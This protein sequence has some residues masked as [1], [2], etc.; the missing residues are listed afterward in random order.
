MVLSTKKSFNAVIG[1]PYTFV[2]FVRGLPKHADRIIITVLN[3][4]ACFEQLFGAK[5]DPF[6][7]KTFVNI[8]AL[9]P[10]QADK[11]IQHVLSRPVLFHRYFDN[12]T[13]L[14]YAF[15]KLPKQADLFME[16][17]RANPNE[18][19]KLFKTKADLEAAARL[20]PKYREFQANSVAE[21][22]K[23]LTD[24]N[25]EPRLL[26]AASNDNAVPQSQG[27]PRK[28]FDPS[29]NNSPSGDKGKSEEDDQPKI[30]KGGP[31]A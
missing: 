5:S 10:T 11:L 16:Y 1:H 29:G 17:F 15:E 2:V 7:Q 4:T 18:F 20:Y 26:A 25:R 22:V 30:D 21:A 3:N 24:K 28:F 19:K 23:I 27:S 9:L 6:L 14:L 8:T 31:T 12:L 13:S